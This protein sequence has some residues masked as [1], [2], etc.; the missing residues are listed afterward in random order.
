MT[1]APPRVQLGNVPPSGGISDRSEAAV[2]SSLG[3]AEYQENSAAVTEQTDSSNVRKSRSRANDIAVARAS[4]RNELEE[5]G[6]VTDAV[7][8]AE[9][10]QLFEAID[11]NGDGFITPEELS[12]RL[13]DAGWLEN[14]IM[15]LFLELDQNLD[16]KVSA[17]EFERAWKLDLFGRKPVGRNGQT[18]QLMGRLRDKVY[19]KW[20]SLRD[21]F[22]SIDI[23]HNQAISHREFEELL[24]RFHFDL[25]TEE[26]RR[27]VIMFD[28][29]S[30]GFISYLEFCAV[31]EC[32]YD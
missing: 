1:A 21:A 8:S 31:G 15:Q 28:R 30:D 5:E 27:L 29:N 16:G 10:K 23:D 7:L 14:H 25:T 24:Q 20:N 12:C 32:E 3:E 18:E 9:A 13:A 26:F 19:Q 11:T 2:P 6:G 22:R 4:H 17:E